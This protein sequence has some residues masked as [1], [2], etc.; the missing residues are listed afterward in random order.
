MYR[1]LGAGHYI[2]PFTGKYPNNSVTS[3][4]GNYARL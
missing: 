3:I 2:M 4:V 1:D